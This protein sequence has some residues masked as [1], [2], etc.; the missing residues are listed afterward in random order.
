[1][2]S[3]ASTDEPPEALTEEQIPAVIARRRI[4]HLRDA[5]AFINETMSFHKDQKTFAS[6]VDWSIREC[7]IEPVRLAEAFE[8]STGTVSRWRRGKNAPHPRERPRVI[9]WI[10]DQIAAR[11]GEIEQTAP[12]DERDRCD[13]KVASR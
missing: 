12:K 6:L 2:D 13:R 10:K 1:M 9:A 7:E 11:A 8:V 5:V 4:D 3:M